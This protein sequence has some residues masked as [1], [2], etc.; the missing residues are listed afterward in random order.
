MLRPVRRKTTLKRLRN[1]LSTTDTP[2]K[3]PKHYWRSPTAQREARSVDGDV[4]ATSPSRKTQGAAPWTSRE[5]QREAMLRRN[6]FKAGLDLDRAI[7][8]LSLYKHNLYLRKCANVK[9]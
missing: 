3:N 8:T 9:I 6:R 2:W 7:A 4:D 1:P 5:R